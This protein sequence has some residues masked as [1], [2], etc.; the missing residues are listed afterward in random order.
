MP[1]R[2]PP[3]PEPASPQEPAEAICDAHGVVANT[4]VDCDLV[5]H[6]PAPHKDAET[7]IEF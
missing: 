2:K 3:A 7:G 6:H 5:A 1:P 4:F